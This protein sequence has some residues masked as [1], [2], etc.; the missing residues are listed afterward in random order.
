MVKNAKLSVLLTGSL[1]TLKF[2]SVP[3]LALKFYVASSGKY[4]HGR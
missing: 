3:H 1:E 4:S 2:G